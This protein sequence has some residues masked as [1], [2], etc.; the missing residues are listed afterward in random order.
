MAIFQFVNMISYHSKT[1]N[2][3]NF[4]RTTM[5][6]HSKAWQ[7]NKVSGLILTNYYNLKSFKEEQD[8]KYRV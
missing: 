3:Y 1:N 5:A 2:N 7:C 4:D 8:I 6:T